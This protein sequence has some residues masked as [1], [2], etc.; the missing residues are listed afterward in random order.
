MSCLFGGRAHCLDRWFHVLV[1]LGISV[2]HGHTAVIVSSNTQGCR[3]GSQGPWEIVPF[4]PMS[5]D[6]SDADGFPAEGESDGCIDESVI[7]P[8]MPDEGSGA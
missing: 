1:K 8:S 6:D 4:D 7:H 3:T 2:A 5:W